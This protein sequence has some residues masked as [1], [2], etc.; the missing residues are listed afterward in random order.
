MSWGNARKESF[1]AR[2]LLACGPSVKSSLTLVTLD[3]TRRN[4]PKIFLDVETAL[5]EMFAS[6]YLLGPKEMTQSFAHYLSKNLVDPY[7][8]FPDICHFRYYGK[9]RPKSF[10]H[11]K[12]CL[13]LSSFCV[14]N[15]LINPKKMILL[16]PQKTPKYPVDPYKLFKNICHVWKYGNN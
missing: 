6:M 10:L 7:K 8:L 16:L 5:F 4:E 12:L 1:T 2:V 9:N 3:S 13:F 15:N 14:F 11:S